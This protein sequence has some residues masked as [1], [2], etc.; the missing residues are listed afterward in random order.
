[1][2][3]CLYFGENAMTTNTFGT[4]LKK[5][6]QN[7]GQ[8]LREFCLKHGFDAGNFSRLER[9]RFP[10]PHKEELLERYALALGLS[11]GSDE[12]IEFFDAAAAGRGEI[13]RDLLDDAQ[14]V[15]K[16]PLL[17]RT[18]RGKQVPPDKLEALIERIRRA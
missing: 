10:P 7:A 1:M 17:F 3:G 4:L 5:H 15:A 18:L 16:L 2:A 9:G 12:W 6:R 11:R 8:T 13:P 14:L